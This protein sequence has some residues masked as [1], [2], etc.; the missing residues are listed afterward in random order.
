[1]KKTMLAILMAVTI[2]L[3]SFA[4]SAHSLCNNSVEPPVKPLDLP[5]IKELT[6]E[7][8]GSYSEGW[9]VTFSVI[10]FD[11]TSGMDRVEF[12]INDDVKFTDDISPYIWILEDPF[13]IPG[14]KTSIIKA[15]A[16]DKAGNSAFVEMPASDIKT[17]SYSHIRSQL[18]SNLFSIKLLERFP[19]AFPQLRYILRFL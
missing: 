16:F 10:C 9:T 2:A 1:M 17:R 11:N 4:A 7:I 3:A 15:T 14:W 6:W 5:W 13:D 12:A 8:S 19:N 18:L